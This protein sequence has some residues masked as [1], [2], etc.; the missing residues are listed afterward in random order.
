MKLR[1]AFDLNFR[2]LY[3]VVDVTDITFF[4]WN[5]MIIWMVLGVE[6]GLI[7]ANISNENALKKQSAL[8]VTQYNFKCTYDYCWFKVKCI[9]YPE[10]KK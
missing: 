2:A 5:G 3:G 1:V 7:N 8:C 9:D 4:L 6:S 10:N